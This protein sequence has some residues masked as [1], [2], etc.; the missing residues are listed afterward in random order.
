MGCGAMLEG[1][2]GSDAGG[3]YEMLRYLDFRFKSEEGEP[4]ISVAML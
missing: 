1:G 4:F 3:L 2:L